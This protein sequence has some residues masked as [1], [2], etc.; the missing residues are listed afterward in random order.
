VKKGSTILAQQ[1]RGEG[2][3][4]FPVKINNAFAKTDSK[5]KVSDREVR[6]RRFLEAGHGTER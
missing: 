4:A 2:D 6:Q 5:F 3:S 1:K